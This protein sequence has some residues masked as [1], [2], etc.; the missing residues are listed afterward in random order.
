MH[1]LYTYKAN[2]ANERYKSQIVLRQR[3]EFSVLIRPDRRPGNLLRCIM[4]AVTPYTL[5]NTFIF[6]HIS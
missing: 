2:E 3:I 4:V 5:S 6:N 1:N